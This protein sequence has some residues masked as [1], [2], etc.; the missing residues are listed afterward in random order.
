MTLTKLKTL[1]QSIDT[2]MQQALI[3]L[4]ILTWGLIFFA[5]G[6]HYNVYN[7]STQNFILYGGIFSIYSIALAFIIKYRPKVQWRL[8]L[9]VT[10][11]IIF[12]LQVSFLPEIIRHLFY[13]LP[14]G[15]Y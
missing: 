3:R 7:L 9:T 4:A 10:I 15:A 1:K 14:I 2:E 6:L 5:I 12:F 11:D 8:Y 13:S